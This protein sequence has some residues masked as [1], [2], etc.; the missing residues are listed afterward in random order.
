MLLWLAVTVAFVVSV[1]AA[2]LMV[3]GLWRTL[4]VGAAYKA[5]I[6]CSAI[7][8]SG[9]DIDPDRAE[10]VSA[11][12]YWTLRFF[13]ARGRPG[14]RALG[15]RPRAAVAAGGRARRSD[16]SGAGARRRGRLPGA[17][18]GHAAPHAGD[19]SRP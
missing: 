12:A 7:F 1:A 5:K 8:V 16:S 18:S 17:G 10:E 15:G 2:A 13:G 19:R 9:R 4:G 3:W 6:L 11:G 14:V